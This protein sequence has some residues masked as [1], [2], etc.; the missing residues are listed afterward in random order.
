MSRFLCI[1]LVLMISFS[2]NALALA[3]IEAKTEIT[4]AKQKPI[5]TD[6]SDLQKVK[7]GDLKEKYS[8]A[9]FIYEKRSAKKNAWD[10]FVEWFN[11][12]FESNTSKNTQDTIDMVKTFG[13]GLLILFVVFLIVKSVMNKEGRW[14]FGKN[15]DKGII[16]HEEIEKNLLLV[17][18]EK[19]I[20]ETKIS[21]ERRLTIRYYYLFLLKKMATQGFIAWD[22]E[23]TN[24]DY[25]R[26]LV[27]PQLKTKF[28]YLSYLYNYIWY[29]E[30]EIDEDALQRAEQAFEQTIKSMPL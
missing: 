22:P 23:K 9:D 2:G 14:I 12:L 30:F 28:D 6:Q 4:Q 1:L 29:G 17:D 7:F 26:E 16:R 25:L 11:G 3:P 27:D 15:S 19:L 5:K 10:R 21:G 24:S 8:G 20:R 13:A 18:F